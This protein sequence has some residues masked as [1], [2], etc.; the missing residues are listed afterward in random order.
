MQKREIKIIMGLGK[1][2]P[3]FR[4][5]YGYNIIFENHNGREYALAA[6][7]SWLCRHH[8]NQRIPSLEH[9]IKMESSDAIWIHYKEHFGMK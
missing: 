5:N 6:W 9:F 2:Y 8:L 1:L 7:A 3:E 4:D